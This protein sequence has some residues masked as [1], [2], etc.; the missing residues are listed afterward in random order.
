MWATAIGST[1]CHRPDCGERKS[2]MPDGTEIPAPVSATTEPAARTS[3]TSL[4]TSAAAP[5]RA[6]M[7]LAAREARRAFGEEGGDPLPGV[8]A[9]EH[10]GER[11]ALR[12]KPLL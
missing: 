4:S 3:S 1:R 7:A 6:R 2:G 9:R 8:G 11:L 10:R 5:I 12:R